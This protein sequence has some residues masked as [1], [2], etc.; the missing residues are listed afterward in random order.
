MEIELED[1]IENSDFRIY[2]LNYNILRFSMG[3][4]GLA[5]IN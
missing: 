5:Y 4:S 2:A 3:L 1:G